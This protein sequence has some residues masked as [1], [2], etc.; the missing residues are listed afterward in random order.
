MGPSFLKKKPTGP[1]PHYR[2]FSGASKL[3]L[4]AWLEVQ[5][6]KHRQIDKQELAEK[7]NGQSNPNRAE[8]GGPVSGPVQ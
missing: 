3:E 8:N 5:K 1:T 4:C 6:D 2:E 7:M